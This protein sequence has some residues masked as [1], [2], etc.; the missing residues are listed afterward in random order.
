MSLK[1]SAELIEKIKDCGREAYPQECC[2]LLLGR[3]N[4]AGKSVVGLRAV[5]NSREDSRE[6]R[7]LISPRDLFNAEK[8]AGKLGLDVIGIYHSHPDHPARPSEFDREH[9]FPWYSYIIL[10]VDHG[11]P[12][13]LASWLLKEDRSSF[14]GEALCVE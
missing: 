13:D 14:D 6:N 3:A 8:D 5:Q 11:K 12:A 1:I 7:Y 9:A 4:G 10:S 2:G